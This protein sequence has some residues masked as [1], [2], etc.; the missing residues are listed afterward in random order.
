MKLVPFISH[1]LLEESE[2]KEYQHGDSRFTGL[3]RAATKIDWSDISI[4]SF[5]LEIRDGITLIE[6][7]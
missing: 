5:A 1:L 2:L 3:R 6:E 7:V 4:R